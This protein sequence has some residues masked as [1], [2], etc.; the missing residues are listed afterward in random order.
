LEKYFIR[1]IRKLRNSNKNNP[2]FTCATHFFGFPF[3]FPIRKF[4]GFFV[5]GKWGK[6]LSQ[7]NRRVNDDFFVAFFNKSAIFTNLPAEIIVGC[8]K[9]RP[10]FPKFNF[11]GK[12]HNR[13]RRYLKN[14]LYLI[15][16]GCKVKFYTI[17]FGLEKNSCEEEN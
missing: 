9:Y 2:G 14:F 16:F 1:P 3:P 13:H 4:S 6:Q 10:Q 15:F 11:F 7:Y 12:K 17:F 8:D 5:N